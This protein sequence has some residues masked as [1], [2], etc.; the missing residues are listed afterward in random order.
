MQSRAVE[1]DAATLAQTAPQEREE[2]LLV[3]LLT[4]GIHT[5]KSPNQLAPNEAVEMA[6]VH[7]VAGRLLTD[8]GYVPFSHEFIG[9]AQLI[10]QFKFADSTTVTLLVT[11]ALVYEYV[12]ALTQWQLISSDPARETVNP[13]AAGATDIELDD[14]TGLTIG[15]YVGIA[16]DDNTQHITQITAFP[17]GNVITLDDAIPVGRS[18]AD[19]AVVAIGVLLAG[20][21][22]LYQVC[23][24]LYA[25]NAWV[26][27]SNN[28]DPIMYY[29]HDDGLIKVLGG[30]PADT[31][32]AAM[33]VFHGM[34]LIGN[35]TE[36]GVHLPNRV[37]QSDVGDPEGWT[38]GTDGVAAIYDLLDTPDYIFSLKLLGPWIICYREASIMRGSFIGALNEIIFWEYMTQADGIQSQG[39]VADVGTGHVIVGT[40][41][42]YAY[43]GDYTLPPIGD[44]VFYNF[45]AKSGDI[46]SPAKQTMFCVFVETLREVWI[47]YPSSA[48]APPPE[49]PAYPNKVLRYNLQLQ[50]WQERVF[51]DL[52]ISAGSY[53]PQETITWATA[54]GEWDDTIWARPW[55][56]RI[57]VQ[58]VPNLF[59][60]PPT[61]TQL[62]VYDFSATTDRGETIEFAITTKEFGDGSLFTRWER[63]VF[64]GIG[65]A[66]AW[67]SI[68]EGT[69]WL[70]LGVL[71]LGATE[72]SQTLWLDST[73]T[74][75][76]LRLTGD[77]QTFQLRYVTIYAEFDSE[78]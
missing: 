11:S 53:T 64:T 40:D 54:P 7:F 56:S 9:A 72:A 23:Y 55:N 25:G 32:C 47:F 46:Y 60:G 17:G 65:D 41:N 75:L 57:N 20:D 36:G 6:G 58:N 4:G 31:T 77:D 49:A 38:P 30:L 12:P 76:M 21:P 18:V 35:T 13:Y 28:V 37:R 22:T 59:L 43:A 52:F 78:W 44:Q 10:Q 70:A 73:S 50:S 61:Q 63:F 3:P 48:V 66:L 24:T 27:F 33:T 29:D 71:E 68:D 62:F 39:A 34:L 1:I 67:Y 2:R 42:V 19:G 51:A 14:I 74:R 26:V 45:L 69:T 5:E 16:L 8:T 15:D